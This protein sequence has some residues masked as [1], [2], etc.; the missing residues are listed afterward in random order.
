MN[1]ARKLL[2]PLLV[3]LF[4][5][6]LSFAAAETITGTIY[7][8][9][10][11]TFYFNGV[12]VKQDPISFTPHNAVKVSFD[13]DGTWPKVYAIACQ[14][15]ATSSGYEYTETSNPQLGD[16]ALIA[17]FSD[18]TKTTTSWKAFVSKS[19]PTPASVS[20]GCSATSLDKCAVS[21]V[22]DPADWYAKTF[23][24][25]GW[26]AAT[27]Y[28]EQQAGWGRT[29]SWKNG[30][31]CTMTSPLTRNDLG[32]SVDSSGQGIAVTEDECQDPKSLLGSSDATFLW[33]PEL[34]TDNRVLFR[35]DISDAAAQSD[36]AASSGGVRFGAGWALAL[37][38]AALACVVTSLAGLRERH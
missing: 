17:S 28:T 33:A 25:S 20:A 27:S 26:S 24:A 12:L 8:D 1:P 5:S 15:F 34:K 13:W 31:C 32:C 7:C 2:S 14:D 19:G 36:M 29:P 30:E 23:D 6:L 18:G 4:S 3:L 9:N 38:C 22:G 37:A 10:Q 11:F 35:M 16:G 21:D